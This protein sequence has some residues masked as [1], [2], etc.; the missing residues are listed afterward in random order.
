MVHQEATTRGPCFQAAYFPLSAGDN[1]S[2]DVWNAC[3]CRGRVE[4]GHPLT[5]VSHEGGFVGG[6]N[7]GCCSGICLAVVRTHTR[8]GT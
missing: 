6:S 2:G 4:H 7:G 3:L 5:T 1:V 8:A